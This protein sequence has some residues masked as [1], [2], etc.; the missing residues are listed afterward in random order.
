[1]DAA[2]C[3]LDHEDMKVYFSGARLDLLIFRE[4]QFLRHNGSLYPV[5]GHYVRDGEPI[6]REFKTEIIELQKGDWVILQTDGLFEQ[7]G[8]KDNLPMLDAELFSLLE[9]LIAN[10]S[11]PDCFQNELQN[12]IREDRRTDDICILGI[13]V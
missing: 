3:I 8:G 4:G 11:K 5:G 9:R 2:I 6:V 10:D 12:W 13:L 1:M 7:P